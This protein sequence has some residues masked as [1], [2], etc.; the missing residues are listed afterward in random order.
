[1]RIPEVLFFYLIIGAVVAI[2]AHRQTGEV[3]ALSTLLWPLL[4][5]ALLARR[6]SR[7][8]T[9]PADLGAAPDAIV[10][11]EQ[12][13]GGWDQGLAPSVDALSGGIAEIAARQAALHAELSRPENDL[14]RLR[15]RAEE[16]SVVGDVYRRRLQNVEAISSLHD[17]LELEVRTA[18]AQVEELCSRVQLAR[19]SGATAEGVGAQLGQLVAAIEGVREIEQLSDK[20]GA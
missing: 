10:R 9:V 2:Y 8:D 16:A 7:Y 6:A 4:L 5:P 19:F 12:V 18:L 13:L 15:E 17:Q 14:A 20:L 1:M 3:G 11:L